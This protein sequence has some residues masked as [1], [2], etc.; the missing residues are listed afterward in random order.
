MPKIE[1]PQQRTLRIIVLAIGALA[2][3]VATVFSPPHQGQ[4]LPLLYLVVFVFLLEL[5]P[6]KL[7]NN[8]FSLIHIILFSAGL[9][10]GSGFAVW[11]C[12]FGIAAAVGIQWISSHQATFPSP[13]NKS[14]VSEGIFDFGLNSFTLVLTLSLFGIPKGLSST[15]LAATQALFLILGA[16]LFFGILHGVSYLTSSRTI[17]AIKR[18]KGNWDTLALTSIEVM[19]VFFGFI[20]LLFYPLVGAGTIIIQ[21]VAIFALGLLIYYLS[22]PR[23]NLERRLQEFSTLEEISRILS[24]D[25][26]LERLL[27]SI[28]VQVTNLLNV[29]NFYVAL[30]DPMDQQIWYPLAVK[31]GIRQTWQRRPITERLT[32]KV[33]LEGQPL[34]IPNNARQKLLKIGFP[35]GEDAP[36]AW[37]GVPLIASGTTIGCLA[38]FSMSPETEFTRDDLNLLSILS[39]QTSVAIEIALHNAL[40]SSDITIGRDRLTT[41]LNSVNDGLIL[42]DSDGKITLVNEAVSF[43]SGLQQSEFIGQG[44][45]DLPMAVRGAMGY[46]DDSANELTNKFNE[47]KEHSNEYFTFK[48]K[49][50]TPEL[51]VERSFIQVHDGADHLIGLIVSLRDVT[52]EYQLKQT[53]DLISETLVHDL[54]SP[55]S[56]TIS[57]LDVISDAHSAG[58]PAGILEPSIQIAQ[59]SS[60]RMLSMVE[61]IL[62]INRMESGII[63]LSLSKFDVGALLIESISE[64]QIISKEYQVEI[65]FEP[66][67]DLPLVKMDENKI[68]RVF[69]NLIDNALK[70][71]PEGEAINIKVE[72]T[73]QEKIEIHV[74]DRGPGI[75]EQYADSIFD[76]FFQ[77]P[78]RPSRKRGTGLGLTYCRLIVEAHDGRMLVEQRHDGG[79]DFIVALPVSTP[80]EG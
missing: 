52:D 11:G 1:T 24:S 8:N 68:Q 28:Q 22:A 57:A 5:L 46:S 71:S 18:I 20:S 37:I 76:R 26:E 15:N 27:N 60:K 40:L 9:L 49:N 69:N 51:F 55:L 16:G 33:I 7:F 75:P 2:L 64:F 65:F 44:I 25:I 12:L 19:P 58:D 30:L 34:L 39:G 43:L 3:I 63:D 73:G 47:S 62:E 17:G 35:V 14:Y 80:E 42:F 32:D 21:G 78:D 23:K 72:T 6:L 50:R 66:G 48:M 29:D 4:L 79:S 67:R 41:I 54:R 56:S 70:F 38:L 36:Y 53:Q 61:S 74:L 31:H 77:I 45:S 59:R 13:N 10:Y